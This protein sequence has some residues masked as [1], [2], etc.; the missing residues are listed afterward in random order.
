MGNGLDELRVARGSRSSIDRI[1][2]RFDGGRNLAEQLGEVAKFDPVTRA[3]DCATARMTDNDN[4]LCSGNLARE[5]EAA[6]D[7]CVD[8]V[9]RDPCTED[10]AQT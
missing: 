2:H 4:E 8:H 1:S 6:Q 9:A 5:L 10:V 3:L 7:V